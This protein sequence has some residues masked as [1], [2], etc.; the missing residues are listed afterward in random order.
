M[1]NREAVLRELAP[2]VRT[3]YQRD[4]NGCCLHAMLD[5]G[6][7][8]LIYEDDLLEH[9]DCRKAHELLQ[10]LALE[11]RLLLEHDGGRGLHFG[12]LPQFDDE[13]DPNEYGEWGDEEETETNSTGD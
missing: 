2:L 7:W 6:N 1:R 4:D 3:I 8:E 13:Y 12:E 9:D 10:E 11:D 5:D